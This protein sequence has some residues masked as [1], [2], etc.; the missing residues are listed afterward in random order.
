MGKKDKLF[1][2][3]VEPADWQAEEDPILLDRDG[4]EIHDPAIEPLPEESEEW[5]GCDHPGCEAPAM[6]IGPI[7]V[8]DDFKCD[9]HMPLVDLAGAYQHLKTNE[10]YG[11]KPVIFND[12]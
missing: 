8:I 5:P 3:Y 10:Y 7:G 4:N 1:D 6:W 9:D 2:S 12:L 11:S